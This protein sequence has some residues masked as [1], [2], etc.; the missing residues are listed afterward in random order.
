MAC[1]FVSC[2]SAE[3]DD[4]AI[5]KINLSVR[6]GSQAHHSTAECCL[7]A[8]GFSHQSEHISPLQHKTKAIYGLYRCMVMHQNAF[9]DGEMHMQI[10]NPQQR[11]IRL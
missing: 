11:I 6:D 2:P 9:T 7:A 10:F 3:P 4:I 1:P 5:I 8:A